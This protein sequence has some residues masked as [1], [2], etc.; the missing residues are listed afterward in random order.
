MAGNAV[1]AQS[2]GSYNLSGLPANLTGLIKDSGGTADVV[3]DFLTTANYDNGITK[4]N[5]TKIMITSG[6]KEPK[7]NCFDL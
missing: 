4:T 3:F 7:I 5:A 6:N 2:D 1:V